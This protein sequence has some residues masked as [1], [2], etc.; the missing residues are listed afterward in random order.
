LFFTSQ[1]I[2]E[3]EAG[4]GVGNV[5]DLLSESD[6]EA[7]VETRRGTVETKKFGAV[8][9]TIRV[10]GGISIKKIGPVIRN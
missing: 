1:Q 4:A 7:G 3:I 5:F 9:T 2:L 6:V 10:V 8:E